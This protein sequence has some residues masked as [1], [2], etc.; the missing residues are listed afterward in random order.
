MITVTE[1]PTATIDERL[2]NPGPTL[3]PWPEN[4]LKSL[5]AART[6]LAT[7]HLLVGP[8]PATLAFTLVVT[9]L[10]TGVALIPVAL[11]GVL[12]LLATV[13]AARGYAALERRRYALLLDEH[14]PAPTRLPRSGSLL[15]RVRLILTSAQTWRQLGYCLFQLP[16][17]IV[18]AALANVVW[19]VPVGLMMMSFLPGVPTPWRLLAPLA[20]L[21]L[22]PVAPIAIRLL[23]GADTAVAR[24]MLGPQRD[25]K[26]AGRVRAL[27]T[28]RAR[29]VDSG[30][31]ERRR[32]E[33]DLHDGAQQRLVSLAMTLGRAQARYDTDPEGAR[34]LLAQGQAEAKLALQE[35]RDLTRGIHPPVLTDRGLDAAL[36][37]LAQRCPVPVTVEVDVDPRPSATIESIAYFVVAEALT[38]VAKHARARCA[39]VAVRRH[40]D[41]IYGDTLHLVILD[42]GIGG[43][44][45]DHGTGLTGLADRISG[46]DGRLSVDSPAGGP[47]VLAVELPCAS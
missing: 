8:I 46:V 43:A 40:R 24:A 35:L 1:H 11:T 2:V 36:S 39:S 44:S 10:A 5:I 16:L 27:E 34:A 13:A 37:G 17:S 14:I 20:G 41:E 28:S 3:P 25:Q 31:A 15:Q 4:P 45:A 32:I 21:A 29:A 22:L 30:E 6:W 19:S 18:L 23:A 7:I 38:N 9:G 42:D 33:R 26:L 47:T 12:V